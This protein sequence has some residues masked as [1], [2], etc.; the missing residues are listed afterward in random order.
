M[1]CIDADFK[2]QP[3]VLSFGAVLWLYDQ[4]ERLE[5]LAGLR[6]N[7]APGELARLN[8]PITAV[9][10]VKQELAIRTGESPVKRSAGTKTKNLEAPIADLEEPLAAAEARGDVVTTEDIERERAVLG[11]GRERQLAI[12]T[13]AVATGD[14]L[15]RDT[16]VKLLSEDPNEL[17]AELDDEVGHMIDEAAIRLRWDTVGSGFD[18]RGRCPRYP[19]RRQ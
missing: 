8:S 6:R 19:Y 17:R 3:L 16:F 13:T 5:I 7:M 18:E 11:A 10:R 9:Q 15:A 2:T 1:V 4:P 14:A 12:A